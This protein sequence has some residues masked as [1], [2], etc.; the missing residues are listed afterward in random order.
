MIASGPCVTDPSTYQDAL[1][2]LDGYALMDAI[3]PVIRERI[4]AGLLGQVPETPKKDDPIFASIKNVIIASNYQ[5][6]QA[7]IDQA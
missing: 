3:P 1:A 5:A 4:K 7:A 6:A 2:I